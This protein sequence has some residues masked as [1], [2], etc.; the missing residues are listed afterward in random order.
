MQWRILVWVICHT[1]RRKQRTIPFRW[2]GIARTLSLDRSSAW[3]TGRSLL[4]MR[5]LYVE[6]ARIGLRREFDTSSEKP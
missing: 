6:N 4:Q 1:A 3:R 2:S 5:V